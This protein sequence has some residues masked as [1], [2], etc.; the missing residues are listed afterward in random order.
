MKQHV[1]Y[2]EACFVS[3]SRYLELIE[4]SNIRLE[5]LYQ[6]KAATRLAKALYE[7]TR[8]KESDVHDKITS[9]LSRLNAEN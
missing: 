3:E 4:L 1:L 6:E 7:G 2:N 9:F 8:M 5:Y